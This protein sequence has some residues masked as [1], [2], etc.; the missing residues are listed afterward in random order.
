MK[1]VR[2]LLLL[3]L[4]VV[5]TYASEY[6]PS[7]APLL[8][9]TWGQRAPY[10]FMCPLKEPT[11]WAGYLPDEQHCRVG[12][13][14]VAMGQIMRY[15]QWPAQGEG[16][17]SVVY[18]VLSTNAN[19]FKVDFSE[20]NYDWDNMIDDYSG[21]YTEAQARA[22]AQLLYHCAVASNMLFEKTFSFSTNFT[23]G[24]A[25]VKYFHYDGERM[26]TRMRSDYSRDEWLNMVREELTN[27]RP[28]FYEAISISLTEGIYAHSFVIDG[29]N[30]D[31]LV[32][33]N[34]G[35]YGHEDGYYDIDLL[36]PPGYSFNSY[37]DMITGIQPI[38]EDTGIN[39]LAND[40]PAADVYTLD[41]RL[42]RR[43]AASLDGL[44][45]GIY[46]WKGKKI[47]KKPY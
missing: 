2:V 45:A 23:A 4:A 47:I 28:I 15:H 41:G 39:L 17:H 30:E 26:Q 5:T 20:A 3:V 46:L 12:C 29:Y 44:P 40:S 43:D 21:D 42:I 19:T 9:S 14:A 18:P 7:V 33:V 38:N 1:I 13:V 6:P 24:D 16:S 22:V 35:W 25:L 31:G 32:H 36:D 27:G 34:W 8:S 37:Q 11:P 10:N